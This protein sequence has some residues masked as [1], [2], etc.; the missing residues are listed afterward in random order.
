ML[1]GLAL[2]QQPQDFSKVQIKI[3]KVADS[4]Y[5]LQGSG[6]NIAASVGNDGILL[7]D[8]EY[9]PLGDKI[10]SQTHNPQTPIIGPQ[11]NWRPNVNTR[12]RLR[13]RRTA[14]PILTRSA[15][16]MCSRLQRGWR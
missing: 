16:G 4:V 13:D 15:T 1:P 5:L 10:Q 12:R 2:A 8:T 7:V 3:A 9:A 14:P 6:G 11:D